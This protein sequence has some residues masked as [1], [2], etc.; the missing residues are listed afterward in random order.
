MLAWKAQY[1]LCRAVNLCRWRAGRGFLNCYV[2]FYCAG[3]RL[4][5]GILIVCC[6][7]QQA[8]IAVRVRRLF[9]DFLASGV[10]HV[11]GIVDVLLHLHL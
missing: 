4:H 2:S 9:D 1:I 7:C 11:T 3:I 8:V 5:Y 10:L 6:L